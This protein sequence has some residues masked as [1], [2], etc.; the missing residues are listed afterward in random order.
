VKP[1]MF[2]VEDAVT[3]VKPGA[4]IEVEIPD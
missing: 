3:H 4:F 2:L 1:Y